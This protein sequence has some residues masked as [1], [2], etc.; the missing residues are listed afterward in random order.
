MQSSGGLCALAEAPAH[1]ARLL[2]SG[3]AGGV[4]AVVAG[5]ARDAVAMDMGGT[6]CDV[7]LI[8][9]GERRRARRADRRR[10]AGAAA[11]A[12]HPHG[13]ARAAGALPGSTSGGA[14]RVG[15]QSAG[16]RSRAGLLRAG[17][18]A[19]DGD[20]REPGAGPA[21][22]GGAAGGRRCASTRRPRGRAVG[23][24]AAGFRSLRAAAEGIV[25]VANQEM[26]RAIRVVTRRAG[27]RPAR[28]RAG[29][30]RR[31]RAAARLRRGRRA[32]GAAG[33]RARR[34]AACCRR[35]ASRRATRRRTPSP[36]VMRPL[37]TMRAAE[38]RRW[39]RAAAEAGG[40]RVRVR[41][42]LPRPGL[43]ADAAAGAASRASRRGSMRRHQER[44]GFHDPGG[45]SRWSTLR[46]ARDRARRRSCGSPRCRDGAPVRGPATVA[47]DGATLWVAPGWTA[48]RRRDGAW[49]VTR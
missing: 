33:R 34:P 49:E 4:A 18:R 28:P 48:R 1:P 17:R 40:R 6:S 44:Y 24:V 30:V 2:L 41:S 11:D 29:R 12:R 46:V 8:R 36:G 39:C 45:R 37:A 38:L 26:V 16:R 3:P 23:Q 13:R 25:A 32:R 21:R 27:A 10:P 43:R 9:G 31:R 47:L 15:P 7:S 42:A 22:P 20:R 35:S 14:L 5:G 19:A